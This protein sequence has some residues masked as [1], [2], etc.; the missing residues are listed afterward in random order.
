M[1]PMPALNPLRLVITGGIGCGKSLAGETLASLGVAVLDSDQVAH[2]LLAGD[3]AVREAI[4]SRFG[5]SVFTDGTVNRRALGSV[6]FTDEHARK[7]L[8]AILHPRIRIRTDEWL[9]AQ[10]S[11]QP[12]AV[13]IPLLYE[14]G[15]DRDFPL[16]ACVACSPEVQHQRLRQRGWTEQEIQRRLAAQLPVE[17]KIKRAQVVIWNDGS[18]EAQAD[19]W[20]L[21]LPKFK[22]QPRQ[23]G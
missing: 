11:S 3:P 9:A 13:I 18:K 8:E 5:P 4:R 22:E 17:E 1:P 7:D 6:V 14:V 21:V 23:P 20:K 2:E 12:A 16:V 10:P 15:R 19:Q